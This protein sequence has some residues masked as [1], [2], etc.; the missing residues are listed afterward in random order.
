MENATFGFCGGSQH[1][2][3]LVACSRSELGFVVGL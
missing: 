2:Q 3:H 1:F